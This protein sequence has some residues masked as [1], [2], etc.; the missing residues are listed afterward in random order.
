MVGYY[1]TASVPIRLRRYSKGKIHEGTCSI[2]TFTCI[3]VYIY[4]YIVRRTP[5]GGGRT[6]TP[7]GGEQA[8]PGGRRALGAMLQGGIRQ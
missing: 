5:A 3:Y 4:I 7:A 1:Y 2:A 6:D 8:D